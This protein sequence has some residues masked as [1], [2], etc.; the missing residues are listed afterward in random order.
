MKSL[1]DTIEQLDRAA[2]DALVA[3]DTATL[4]RLLSDRLVFVHPTGRVDTKA[5]FI[6]SLLDH[7][8]YISYEVG[9]QTILPLGDAAVVA[10]ELRTVFLRSAAY[11]NV[12]LTLRI[13]CVWALEGRE[14]RL[15][16]Y[17]STYVNIGGEGA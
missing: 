1:V 9:E 4:D 5:G 7:N 2:L 12:T 15:I 16:R 14:W 17:Q 10:G 8:P 6:A 11:D 13:T 3:T